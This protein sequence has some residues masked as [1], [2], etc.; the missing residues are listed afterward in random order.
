MAVVQG[1]VGEV[2]A[3]WTPLA[4]LQRWAANP[5]KNAQAV[6][7]VAESIS[8]FG[9]AA[10]ILAN[11][12][13]GE[14][15]AGDTRF[16]AAV[17]LKLDAVPVRWL[18]L[19]EAE[20]HALAVADNKLGELADWDDAKLAAVLQELA[21]AGDAA[22]SGLGFGD[23]ELRRLLA[24]ADPLPGD[25]DVVP[26]LRK[27]APASS[28]PGRVYELGAHR[29]ACGDSRDFQVWA[30]LLAGQKLDLVWTDPPYGVALVGGCRELSEGERR[31]Q[32]KATLSGDDLDEASFARLLEASLG[33]LAVFSRPG[34]VWYVAGPSGPMLFH[35]MRVLRALKVWRQTLVWE[36]DSFVLGRGDFHIRDETVLAGVV[37]APEEFDSIVYGWNPGAAHEWHGGRRLDSVLRFA[38]PKRSADHPS[39]KPVDLVQA[40]LRWSSSAG[41]LV[42]D[43]FGGSG[44]T[45]IA[46]A[47]EHR[48]ARLVDVDPWYCDVIRRRWTA[49]AK[50]NKLEPGSGGLE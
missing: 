3:V 32:G 1:G 18:D 9:F 48:R 33:Q 50:A 10:P 4:E 42:G 28:Q 29:L 8:R 12:R 20:A 15:V 34:A 7:A 30:D 26:E 39:Q 14:I 25:G 2:A 37:P 17:R 41:D 11:R 35:W 47:S 5:R 44:T 21:Q 36:K 6:A 23:V 22:V 46:A 19:S 16:Q 45:L 24:Q 38:R 49:Y 40:C 27:W 31:A 13:T 43:A